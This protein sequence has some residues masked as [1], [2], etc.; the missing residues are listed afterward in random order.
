MCV[1][2]CVYMYVYICVYVYMYVYMCIYMC[3]CVPSLLLSDRSTFSA[4]VSCNGGEG[5]GGF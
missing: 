3:M 2:V 5:G 4:D 1:C